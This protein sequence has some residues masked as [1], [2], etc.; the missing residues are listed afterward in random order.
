MA[1]PTYGEMV[2][3]E[4]GG[5]LEAD[6]PYSPSLCQSGLQQEI[7]PEIAQESYSPQNPFYSSGSA[8]ISREL[9]RIS[10]HPCLGSVVL[11]HPFPALLGC[12]LSCVLVPC[13]LVVQKLLYTS[14]EASWLE[15]R[16]SAC[17]WSGR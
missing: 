9:L 16:S 12:D 1:N 6:H 11:V 4:Q 10:V 8:L 13:C 15:G 14:L 5:A 17:Q 7:I 2:K 3:Q